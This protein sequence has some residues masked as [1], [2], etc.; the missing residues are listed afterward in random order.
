MLLVPIPNPLLAVVVPKTDPVPNPPAPDLNPDPAELPPNPPVPP[1]PVVVGPA[2]KPVLFEPDPKALELAGA[3][4]AVLVVGAP[5][6]VLVDPDPNAELPKLV[7]G[8]CP[9]GDP[10][11][12]D[13]PNTFWD[14][15][16]GCVPN[17]VPNGEDEF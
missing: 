16:D 12:V 7:T 14:W 1:N 9:K 3:P 11:G 10:K 2:P 4:K 8:L 6:A 17:E 15:F 5:K 13:P